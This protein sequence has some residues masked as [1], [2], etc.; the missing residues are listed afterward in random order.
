MKTIPYEADRD[1]PW[2]SGWW[3]QRGAKPPPS[4]HLPRGVVAIDHDHGPT[5]IAFYL[6]GE[7]SPIVWISFIVAS[8]TLEPRLVH[9][10][11]MA[12]VNEIAAQHKGMTLF[13]SFANG[14]VPTLE[15]CGF[16]VTER[17]K[18]ELV[19]VG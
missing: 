19:K 14:L 16:F 4:T 18:T 5:A 7:G 12:A 1:Y 6:R 3:T 15:R 10:G 8:P 13:A 11:V 9:A 2:A 17:D